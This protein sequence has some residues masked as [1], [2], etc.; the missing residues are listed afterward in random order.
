MPAWKSITIPSE[1]S[2][3][4]V[5]VSHIAGTSSEKTILDFF[6]FCGKIKEFELAKDDDEKHQVALIHFERES[7]AKTAVLLSNALIDDSHIVVAP[8]FAS[9]EDAAD[10]EEETTTQED[11]PKTRIIAEL[12]AHGYMLQDQVVA[13]GL[14]Y[15]NKYAVQSRVSSYL[16]GLHTRAKQLD[17][18]YRIWEKTLELDQKYKI[19]EKAQGAFNIAQAKA[20]EALKTPTGQRVQDIANQTLAQV[21]AVHYEAKKIQGEKQGA[22]ATAATTTTEAAEPTVTAPTA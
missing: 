2:P 6:Q 10:K 17:D 15:D 20:Q 3:N 13:K 5:V 1:P 21:T 8:Y 14:E 18:K 12:L 7:A 9:T 22:T 16:T 11:K 4:Y 19:Q